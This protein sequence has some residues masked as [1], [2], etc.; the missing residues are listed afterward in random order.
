MSAQ[1]QPA[2]PSPVHADLFSVACNAYGITLEFTNPP[3]D[4]RP[5]PQHVHAVAGSPIFAK[6]LAIVLRRCVRGY[7][8]AHGPIQIPAEAATAAGISATEDW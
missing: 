1:P 6:V 8:D 4:R 2:R 5:G 7:E 3:T